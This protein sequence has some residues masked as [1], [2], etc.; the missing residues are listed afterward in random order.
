MSPLPLHPPSPSLPPPPPPP[1]LIH[2]AVFDQDLAQ[3]LPLNQ[4]A[5]DYVSDVAR[6]NDPNLTLE[7]VR[8][9][10]GALGLT[11][12]LPL[13][14]GVC[15]CNVCGGRLVGGVIV[16]AVGFVGGVTYGVWTPGGRGGVEVACACLYA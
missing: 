4:T 9:A 1:L 8:A 13:Q 7:R 6:R 5:L 3:E 2:T 15:V 10:L 16:L 11:G 12:S 14:V